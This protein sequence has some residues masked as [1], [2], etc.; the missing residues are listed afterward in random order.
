M[1]SR[2]TWGCDG[3]WDWKKKSDVEDHSQILYEQIFEEIINK[4]YVEE[5]VGLNP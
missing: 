5:E 2:L 4:I 1:D 3:L